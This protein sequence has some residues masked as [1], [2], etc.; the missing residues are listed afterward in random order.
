M[1]Y[2]YVNNADEIDVLLRYFFKKVKMR[3][4]GIGKIF[5]FIDTISAG[6][7]IEFLYPMDQ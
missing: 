5:L 4:Q 7:Q 6:Y 3:L 2:E 1:R